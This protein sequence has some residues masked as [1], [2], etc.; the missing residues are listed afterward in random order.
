MDGTLTGTTTL[1]QSGPGS[2]G[3]EGLRHISQSSRSGTSPSDDLGIIQD[4][5]WGEGL[6]PSA[7][8]MLA[9]STALANWDTLG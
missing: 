3:N 5:H 6:T 2:N 9:Y 7:K 8:M 4:T 1:D